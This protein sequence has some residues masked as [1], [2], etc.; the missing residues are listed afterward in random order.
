MS[1]EVRFHGISGYVDFESNTRRTTLS[2]I[3]QFVNDDFINIGYYNI[4]PRHVQMNPHQN[5]NWDKFCG[6]KV[7]DGSQAFRKMYRYLLLC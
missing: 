6:K 7:P 4:T 2:V 5:I 1:K 3:S